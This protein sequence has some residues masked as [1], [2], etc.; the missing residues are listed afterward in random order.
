MAEVL[1]RATGPL[2]DFLRQT[3]ILERLS[4]PLCEAL[5]GRDDS[6]ATLEHL[7]NANLFLTPLDNR[8]EWYRYHGLFAEVLRLTLTDQEQANL[9]EKA[10]R[11]FEAYG[12]GD[13]A[14]AHK[15]RRRRI[16][17]P[18]RMWL[19][20]VSQLNLSLSP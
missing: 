5:T 12:Y 18:R 8:R 7:E 9:H 3:S 13:F 19:S 4:A 6:Q 20:T 11:W 14:M 10:A 2:R 1:D 16:V 17:P 15:A